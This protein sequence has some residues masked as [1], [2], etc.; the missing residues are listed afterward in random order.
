MFYS[1]YLKST[2]F[3]NLRPIVAS[4]PLIFLNCINRIPTTDT[5][6]FE[7]VYQRCK[8][9]DISYTTPTE[10]AWNTTPTEMSTTITES[11]TEAEWLTTAA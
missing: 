6:K 8:A 4:P 7:E 1:G 2:V 11:P 9:E 3:N 5:N 10:A